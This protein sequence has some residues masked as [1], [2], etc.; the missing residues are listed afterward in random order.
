[1]L[2]IPKLALG[3]GKRWLPGVFWPASPAYF[4]SHR[5][6]ESL[7]QTPGWVAPRKQ[8]L[9]SSPG[10]PMHIHLSPQE[11]RQGRGSMFSFLWEWQFLSRVAGRASGHFVTWLRLALYLWVHW[12]N[13]PDLVEPNHCIL[14]VTLKIVDM[15]RWGYIKLKT[16]YRFM[17]TP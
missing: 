6:S 1:M 15:L 10:L 14:G 17:I 2:L 12:C 4:V 9:K 3:S 8:W 11:Q 13:F 16:K 7:S 5:L